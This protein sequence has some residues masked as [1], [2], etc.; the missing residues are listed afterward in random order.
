MTEQ[1]SSAASVR[2]STMAAIVD[3][4]AQVID[5]NFTKARS[6]EDV[7]L[8]AAKGV[9]NPM[10]PQ[11]VTITL[12]EM[13]QYKSRGRVIAPP[14]QTIELLYQQGREKVNAVQPQL[15]DVDEH[16]LSL[17][18]LVKRYEVNVDPKDPAK[19]VGLTSVEA[20]RRFDTE[21]AN[22]LTPP[23]SENAFIQYIKL[24]RDPL[25]I[26][27][28]VT[29]VLSYISQ[30]FATSGDRTPVYLASVLL[31]VILA[32]T[33]VDFIQARKSAAMLKSLSNLAPP[34]ALVLRDGGA[35]EVPAREL[36]RGDL[37]LLTAGDKVSGKF[38]FAS[39]ASSRPSLGAMTLC[40]PQPVCL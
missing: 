15:E 6:L 13:P 35:V 14:R 17:D 39:R 19:S 7:E 24:L 36:V 20:K 25:T 9:P 26:M 16:M 34:K 23:K 10:M 4:P 12:G 30:A 22:E 11:R 21:G 32:N 40:I 28:I 33:G 27:L 31:A 3:L 38:C 18:Q 1:T 8:A 29:A 37:L 2:G 5:K